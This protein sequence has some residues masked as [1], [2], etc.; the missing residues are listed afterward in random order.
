VLRFSAILLLIALPSVPARAQDLGPDLLAAARKGDAAAVKALLAKGANV[1]AKNAYGATAL[2]FAADWGHLEVV[3]VLLA[4]KADVNVKDTFYK[5]TPL[6]WAVSRGHADIVKALVEAGATGTDS[7]LQKMASTGRLDV[8]QVIIAKTKPGEAAMTR[9]LAATPANHTAVIELLK[10]AGAKTS[11]PTKVAVDRKVLEGYAGTY[12][13]D[14]D[15]EFKVALA[16]DK[17][18]LQFGSTPGTKL[19]ALDKAKFQSSD[20]SFTVTFQRKGDKVTGLTLKTSAAEM[21][22]QRSE[23]AAA[24]KAPAGPVQDKGGVVKAHVNWPSFRGRNASGVADG[25]YPP[26][27]WDVGKNINIRWKTPIPGLGHSCPVVWGDRVWVTTAVSGDPKVEFR[28]GQYGNVDSVKETAEHA[29]RVYCL[30]RH[31]GKVLWEETAC[32]GV[33]RIKRHPKASHA[34]PTPATDGKHVVV[35]F[36]S[37]GLYCYSAD[38]KLLWQKSLGVLDSGWFYDAQYQWGFG[39]SPILYQGLVIVQ[40]DVGKD[41]F[42]AAYHVADGTLVW[43]QARDEIPSWGTPTVIEGP[44]RAELVTNATKYARGYDPR[45]GAELWRLG[46]NAEITVPTPFY[47]AGLIFITSGYSPVQPIYAVRPGAVGDITVKEGKKASD[48]IAWSTAKGGPYMPTPIVYGQYLYVCANAGIVT[49]YEATTGKQTYKERLGGRGGYTAS[50]VA[51]DGYLYFT[52]EEDGIRVVKAGPKFELVAANALGE[53]CMATP[54]ITGGMILVRT[55]HHLLGIGRTAAA[56]SPAPE[57]KEQPKESV[58]P[59]KGFDVPRDG[60]AHGKVETV[61]YDSTSVGARR[62]MLVYTPPGYTKDKRYPVL[63]LLHGLAYDETSWVKKGAADV[64]LDNLYAD[65]KLV[66]MIVVMPNG[67]AVAGVSAKSV[68]EQQAKAFAAFADDLLKDIIPYIEGHYTA[69]TGPA[70]RALA[71]QSMGGGQALNIGLGHLDTFAWVGGFSAAGNTKEA[72]AL[73]PNAAA[74]RKKLRLLWI[75]CG[76]EDSLLERR[77]DLHAALE[78]LK[79]PHVWH[80]GAGGHDWGVWK[81]DLYFFSQQLFAEK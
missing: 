21:V 52:S 7:A 10:K 65:G 13:S 63:Y 54:A 41:S 59:P 30:D 22:F 58:M 56:A 42:L 67:R 81:T 29:W 64:I 27:T 79:V 26:L 39:S 1:N 6:S 15:L 68:F 46:R 5:F 66:P 9:A 2:S 45:T 51:A 77:R 38:G 8:V 62:Q 74:A 31:T 3:K 47:A 71:G 57:K 44:Q 80:V 28:P 73:V 53:P 17:L 61:N 37:E 49:C 12:R 76:D 78:E 34:N 75:S 33:P 18:T 55:Q 50:P 25:Q 19:E 70:H 32:K 16:G 20:G 23:A 14:R 35:S 24:P 36:G 43:R 69:R 72:R 40:C 11:A 4:N 48:A 60:I